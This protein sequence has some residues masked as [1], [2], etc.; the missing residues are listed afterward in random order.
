MSCVTS[1]VVCFSREKISFRS[2]C[3]RRPNEWIERAERFVEQQDLGREH[4]RA[5]Q[6]DALALPAGELGRI[7]SER[8]AWKLRERAELF[9]TRFHFRLGSSEVSRHEENVGARRQ[10]REE[11]ALLDDVADAPTNLLRVR[12]R[13]FLSVKQN[14]ARVRP[15]EGD[16]EAKQRR[17]SAAARADQARSLGRA[18]NRDRSAA[19]R[20]RRRSFC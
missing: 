18:G 8:I 14:L 9:Q 5:H 7:T 10:V 1:N 12:V 4:E 17:F 6:A 15:E 16:N 19:A 3:K 11:A 20:W 13:H 2:R